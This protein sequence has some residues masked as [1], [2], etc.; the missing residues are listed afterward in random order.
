[1]NLIFSLG[2][3]SVYLLQVLITDFEH[4]QY[5]LVDPFPQLCAQVLVI[6]QYLRLFVLLALLFFSLL[7]LLHIDVEDLF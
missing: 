1:M 3:E 5:F 7:P 6:L 2:L 4:D